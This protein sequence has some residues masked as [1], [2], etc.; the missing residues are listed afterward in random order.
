MSV[1]RETAFVAEGSNPVGFRTSATSI[2]KG[3][4]VV[5]NE[6]GVRGKGPIGVVGLGEDAGVRGVGVEGRGED[7]G[8]RGV[9]STAGV[10]GVCESNGRGG[11]FVSKPFRAQVNLRPHDVAGLRSKFATPLEFDNLNGSTSSALPAK[12]MLG[13]LWVS[14]TRV[15]DLVPDDLP[16]A[17]LN[18][19]PQCHLWLCVRN[20]TG[21]E[22]AQWAQ[23]LLGTMCEGKH[24]LP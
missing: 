24:R 3:V 21:S 17:G 23:V 20:S 18:V 1:I 16:G 5:G 8:V 19:G 15:P 13:D 2:G 10:R 7:A 9:G 14:T 11:E 4:D 6:I 12:G 22:N